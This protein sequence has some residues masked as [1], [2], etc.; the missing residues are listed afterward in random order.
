MLVGRDA[1]INGVVLGDFLFRWVVIS[2]YLL[3]CWFVGGWY[4]VC[5]W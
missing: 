5:V 2:C 1:L 3:L 4:P